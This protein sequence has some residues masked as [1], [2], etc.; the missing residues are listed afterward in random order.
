MYYELD[1]TGSFKE[2]HV[3]QSLPETIIS[4]H[5]GP[6]PEGRQRTRLLAIGCSDDAV[7]IISLFPE[8]QL[9]PLSVQALT[10]NP[11]SVLLQEIDKMQFLFVGLSSGIY[12]RLTVDSNGAITDPRSRQIGTS[13]IKLSSMIAE[14][15]Q[16][17][18]AAVIAMCS[19]S[20]LNFSR[21][22]KMM[23]MTS[24]FYEPF[25]YACGF[26]SEQFASAI[27]GTVDSSL[28]IIAIDNLD[29]AFSRHSIPL[30]LMCRKFFYQEDMSKFLLL[31][32]EAGQSVLQLLNPYDGS[33]TDLLRVEAGYTIL[34]A[35]FCTFHT[36]LEDKFLAVGLAKNFT[37]LPR[38]AESCQIVLYQHSK[39]TD[40]LTLVHIT[41][42]EQIP[43]CMIAFDGRLLVGIGSI[44]RLYDVGK[45][46]LL[47]KC[48]TRIQTHAISIQSQGRRLYIADASE[49]VHC[50]L[51]LP[52]DNRFLPFCG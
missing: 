12:I 28:R 7:R 45:K 4:M 22:G 25:E 33:L 15:A 16:G 31:E 13:P 35:T 10:S 43:S 34:S 46:K 27:V 6:V 40:Q 19:R 24:L 39:D 44:L 8:D 9:E 26:K 3:S 2:V 18:N 30:P 20:W 5:I 42:V 23:D 38:R 52:D 37:M 11:T 17:Q 1:L 49:S 36:H 29:V 47:R 41:E 14:T 48:E 51:Y 21:Q 50:V 32:M